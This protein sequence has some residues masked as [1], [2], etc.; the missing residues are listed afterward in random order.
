IRVLA[1]IPGKQAVGVEVP[2]DDRR[3]VH[4]GDVFQDAPAG[5]SPLTVWLGKDIAGK[6][7]GT[8]LAKQPHILVAGTTGPG[9]SGSVNAMLSA[10][11]MRPT[12]SGRCRTSCA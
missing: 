10:I 9:K 2:N 1:P 6:A 5:W 12:A 3:L 11:L 4:L 8:D 7:I